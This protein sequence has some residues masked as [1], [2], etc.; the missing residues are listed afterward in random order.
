MCYLRVSG[1]MHGYNIDIYIYIHN[2]DIKCQQDHQCTIH[3]PI[4]FQGFLRWSTTP[5]VLQSWS[6]VE[7]S[8]ASE[9]RR[10]WNVEN[11]GLLKWRFRDL[12]LCSPGFLSSGFNGGNFFWGYGILVSEPKKFG[13]FGT[14]W[15]GQFGSRASN[16]KMRWNIH[17]KS[18]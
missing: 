9:K 16:W 13:Q 2:I 11:D 1:K 18:I 14:C 12:K 5:Q 4:P 10:V 8:K 3:K 7:P 15:R 6:A 17:H